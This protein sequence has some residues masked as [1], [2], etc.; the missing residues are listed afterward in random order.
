M[1]VVSIKDTVT[2]QNLATLHYTE[3]ESYR[4]KSNDKIT[5]FI[6]NDNFSPLF[7]SVTYGDPLLVA[8]SRAIETYSNTI[9]VW[10]GGMEPEIKTEADV[11]LDENGRVKL[12]KQVIY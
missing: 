3:K 2:G 9:A 12:I 7:G 11:E 4:W 10:E 6:F 1:V 5:Q 8:V